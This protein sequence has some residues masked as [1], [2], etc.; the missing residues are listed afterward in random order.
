MRLPEGAGYARV[1]FTNMSKNLQLQFGFDPEKARKAEEA[2]L[3]ADRADRDR[4]LALQK[5]MQYH[6][7]DLHQAYIIPITASDFPETAKAQEVCK[8]ILSDLKGMNKA[9]E[10]GLSYAKFSDLLTETAIS[11]EKTKDLHG[12]GLPPVFLHRVDDCIDAYKESRDWW[13]KSITGEGSQ[14]LERCFM[15]EYWAYASLYITY[16]QGIAEKNTRMNDLAVKQVAEIIKDE[17]E[18]VQYGLLPREHHFDPDVANL[19]AAQILEKLKM[20]I[21]ATNSLDTVTRQ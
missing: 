17:Q 7:I 20:R 16:C 9:L 21:Q 1:G 14:Y 15:R 13:N 18:N 4:R 5:A 10:I 12:E 3:A 8:E 19:T 6:S 11:I 2:M